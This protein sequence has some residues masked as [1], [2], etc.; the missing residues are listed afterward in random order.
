MKSE[1]LFLKRDELV[2]FLGVAGNGDAGNRQF[3]SQS[4]FNCGRNDGVIAKDFFD[5]IGIGCFTADTDASVAVVR[6]LG[7]AKVEGI[8]RHANQG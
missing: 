8:G 6:E 5:F 2:S 3:N 1:D 4:R 7:T